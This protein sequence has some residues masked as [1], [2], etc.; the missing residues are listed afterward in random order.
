MRD[1]EKE[2]RA[3]NALSARG[4]RKRKGEHI[5]WMEERLEAL[6]DEHEA[7]HRDMEE[8]ERE[9]I[10]MSLMLVLY[11]TGEELLNDASEEGSVAALRRNALRGLDE[12]GPREARLSMIRDICQ[13]DIA[14]P[15]NAEV[16]RALVEAPEH[17]ITDRA[18]EAVCCRLLRL[19]AAEGEEE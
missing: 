2:R 5:R 13:W 3:R 7:M 11:S 8:L 1:S 9:N 18:I 12:G 14:G 16:L 17:R 10:D 6:E 15:R 4:T 19:A